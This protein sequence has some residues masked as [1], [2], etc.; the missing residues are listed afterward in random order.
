MASSVT[1]E[2]TR[3]PGIYKRTGARGTHYRVMTRDAGG[4]Q[5]VRNFDRWQDAVDHRRKAGGEDRPEDARAGRRTLREVYDVQHAARSYAPETLVLHRAAWRYLEPLA[6]TP[7]GKIG[8]G[9]VDRTLNVITKPVMRERTRALLSVTFNYAIEKRWIARN[10]VARPRRRRT[11][12]ELLEQRPKDGG[13]PR[14]LSNEELARLLGAMPEQYRALVELMAR[15]GL[16][17][18]E[19]YAL[20][21]RKFTPATEVPERR[22]AKLRI[23]AST[24]GPTKTGETRTLALPAAI[25]ETLADHLQRFT[26]ADPDAPIFG[27]IDDDN[28]RKRTFARAVKAAGIEGS[29]SPNAL[30]HTAA[31]FAISTGANVYDVQRMLGH[32][33]A[34]V[35]LNVYG[36][37]FDEQHERFIES[38]DEAIRAARSHVPVPHLDD[39]LPTEQNHMR[40]IRRPRKDAAERPK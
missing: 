31:A 23:D 2:R 16:R 9:A 25:A 3:E 26:P 8:P 35:T 1:W 6:D 33:N 20:T 12:A 10:P 15:M 29:L 30:R 4:R 11:R 34:S 14:H 19:A 7:I 22:P 40:V 32:A 5:V 27:E 21:R 17:P 24:S 13:R 36:D 38:Y 18:G 39:S 28:F 37:L